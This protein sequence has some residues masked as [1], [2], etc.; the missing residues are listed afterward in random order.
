MAAPAWASALSKSDKRNIERVQKCALSIILGSNYH[1]YENALSVL[2][3]K[4]LDDRRINLCEKFA[5]KAS[6]NDQHKNWFCLAE[7]SEPVN[8]RS[9]KPVLKYKE[10]KTRTGRFANS[11]I[12]YLTKLLNEKHAKT[13][14][15]TWWVKYVSSRLLSRM[16]FRRTNHI[17]LIV[18]NLLMFHTALVCTVYYYYYYYKNKK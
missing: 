12:P 7:Q 13:W 9:E 2:N 18:S 16:H 5:V 17:A 11:P 1:C 10:P 15:S 4:R 8:T 3:L 6:K 14:S